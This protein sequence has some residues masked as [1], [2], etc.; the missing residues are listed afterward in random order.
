MPGCI[1]I[2]EDQ[3]YAGDGFPRDPVLKWKLN[4]E[5]VG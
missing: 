3:I 5:E 2:Y 4:F 1:Y